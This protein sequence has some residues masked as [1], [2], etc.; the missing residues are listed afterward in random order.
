MYL[1]NSILY[2]DI[3]KITIFLIASLSLGLIIRLNYLEDNIPLTLDSL[4][5]FLLATDI[6]IL[7]YLPIGHN[8]PNNGWPLF[9]SIIFQTFSS[10][11]FLDYMMIQRMCSVIL[12]V[13]TTIPLFFLAK[14]FFKKE[15]AMVGACFFIFSPY[16]IENSLLGI[17]DS[18]FIFLTTSFLALFFSK[19]K[20]NVL[21]S[22]LILGLS[23]FI[24]YESFL[25]IFPAVMIFIYR[26]KENEFR[27]YVVVGIILFFVVITPIAIWNYQ[28][29]IPYG[30]TS[31][32]SSGVNVVINENSI[33]SNTSDRFDIVRGIYKLPQYFGISLLPLCFIFIPYS[34]IPLL[35]KQ[36]K[37]FRYLVYFG[38][39][40]AIPAF[41]AYSRGFEEIRYMLFISPVLIV[42][43]LFLIEKLDLRVKKNIIPISLIILI[44]LSSL[45]YLDFRQSNQEYELEAIEV[46]RFVSDIPGKVNGYGTEAYY[47]EVVE[48]ENHKFPILSSEIH[49]PKRLTFASGN[50]L[51]EIFKNFKNSETEYLAIKESSV[52]VNPVLKEIFYEENPYFVKI[53]DSKENNLKEFS[54]KIFRID[55]EKFDLRN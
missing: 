50:T 34:I 42:A 10:E 51:D 6:S 18:L 8:D 52:E 46:A 12:S 19:K 40:S 29:G 7:G 24:R 9:L 28:M 21:S 14:K 23:T 3:S 47:V 1:K 43:S 54:I 35:K 20:V 16:M 11:N 37:N 33:N 49:F 27:K 4:D 15:I 45:I 17:T 5:Y 36:N 13:L 22:F 38:I 26:Y 32:V 2:S 48:L 41:Y 53:Y 31:S 55:F 25:L 30:I 44:I 39:V